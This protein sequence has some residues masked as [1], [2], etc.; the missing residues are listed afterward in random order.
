MFIARFPG[1]AL[2]APHADVHYQI[3]C[4]N[5]RTPLSAVPGRSNL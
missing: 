3:K 4:A 2:P 5:D 1:T